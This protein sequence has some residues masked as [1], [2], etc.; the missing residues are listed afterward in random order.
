MFD[1]DIDLLVDDDAEHDLSDKSVSAR[2]SNITFTS[3][4]MNTSNGTSPWPFDDTLDEDEDALL[5]RGD[6]SLNYVDNDDDADSLNDSSEPEVDQ[7]QSIQM[8]DSA[9]KALAR[10]PAHSI[11]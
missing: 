8:S 1:I 4:A 3:T 9:V 2:S 6:S 7:L 11:C 5:F 10:P